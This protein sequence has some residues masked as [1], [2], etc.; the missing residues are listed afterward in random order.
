VTTPRGE[1]WF[2]AEWQD[3]QVVLSASHAS[4][5]F[6]RLLPALFD[7]GLRMAGA[8]AAELVESGRALS[9]ADLPGLLAPGGLFVRKQTAAF[10]QAEARLSNESAAPLEYPLGGVDV[11]SEYFVFHVAPRQPVEDLGERLERVV[12]DVEVQEVQDGA[13]LATAADD[14]KWLTRVLRRPDGQ[15]QIWPAWG[16]SSFARIAEV[17][18]AI[19]EELGALSK[20]EV[21][22]LGR[23]YDRALR[24]EVRA[25][26]SGLG[27]DFYA[28]AQPG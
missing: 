28:W 2:L 26:I 20:G 9:R 18:V 19:A 15:W 14:D 13:F 25:R 11:V 21:F 12:E 27:V 7:H 3:G 8:L 23:P 10:R 4:P 6:L 16:A 1:P 24:D 5:H 22:F 17:T